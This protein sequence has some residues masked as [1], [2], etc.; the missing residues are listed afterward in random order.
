MYAYR[1]NIKK[2]IRNVLYRLKLPT[3]KKNAGNI[4]VEES[5]NRK[6]KAQD[7]SR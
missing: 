4:V 6:K 1:D 5:N 3:W 2:N 7:S